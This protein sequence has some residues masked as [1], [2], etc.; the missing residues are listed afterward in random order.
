MGA[1]RFFVLG[2]LVFVLAEGSLPAGVIQSCLEFATQTHTALS[3]GV[4]E[5]SD[6][7]VRCCDDF[8]LPLGEAAQ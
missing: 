1:R 4:G 8:G 2:A 7:L 6:V 5:L 3:L